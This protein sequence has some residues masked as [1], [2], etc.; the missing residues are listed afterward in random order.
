[1][2]GGA[3]TALTQPGGK[4]PVTLPTVRLGTTFTGDLDGMVKRRSI[5]VIVPYSKTSYFIDKGVQRGVAYDFFR[6]FEEYVNT[7]L[8]TGNL[9]V[10]VVFI[11]TS[12]DELAN[13]LFGGKGDIA[14]GNITI[15]D[16]RRALADFSEPI[17]THVNEIV[18]TGPGGPA[19]AGLDDLAGDTVH[20]RKGSIYQENLKTASEQLVKNG[21]KPIT[22]K[23]LPANL[24]DEDILEMA[25]AGLI[26]TTVVD[27]H[28]AQFWKQIFTQITVKS[29]VIVKSDL[30]VGYAMRKNSP[31][32]KAMLDG[33]VKTHR[34]GTAAGNVLLTKYLKSTKFVKSATS[35]EQIKKFQQ[36]IAV[37][38]KYGDQYGVDWVLMAA[39]GYQESG[40][41]QSA[42]SAV[43]AIGVMQVMP[44]T[45]KD[46]KVGDIQQV[47]P[48]INAGIK[49]IRFMIDTFYMGEPMD[50]LNKA[51]FA[52]AAYNAGPGRVKDLRQEAQ[53]TGLD[54]NVWFN[55]VERIASKRIGRETVTYVSNIYKYYVAYRLSIEELQERKKTS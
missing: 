52:F 45:G 4:T 33:F 48:N 13:A 20:V 49:Y 11:P 44:D 43:G 10:H 40:L 35:P 27:E 28:I 21:Q 23:E 22:I 38:R 53:R 7:K 19:I 46:M 34:A 41:N 12:R 14:A 50:D 16:A 29:D 32:L 26:H 1:M 5:R 36:L 30:A 15:T 3:T 9:R 24:E 6:L 55:N 25:N 8:K 37:F 18:V 51:L 31:Q 17:G 47:E 2:P 39:Q 54:P 42:K